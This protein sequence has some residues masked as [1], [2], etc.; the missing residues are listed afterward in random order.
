M[1]KNKVLILTAVVLLTMACGL[2]GLTDGLVEKALDQ[3]DLPEGAL[4][5]A[6]AGL[7][8]V[9]TQAAS[10]AEGAIEDAQND[11]L[12]DT[13][14]QMLE[15]AAGAMD[16]AD[17]D[18]VPYPMPAD[19]QI[20]DFSGGMVTFQTNMPVANVVAF[21][22]QELAARGYTE[23]TI[24]TLVDEQVASLVFDGDPSGIELVVQ[25]TGMGEM[26]IVNVRLEDI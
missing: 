25:V 4:E 16:G 1:S 19:A 10:A 22:R 3:A 23:R 11:E 24:N 17:P 15:E 14:N 26:S 13:I 6:Q 21:Y 8:T 5:T 18:Q 20:Y 7:G 12:N 2:G 9:A